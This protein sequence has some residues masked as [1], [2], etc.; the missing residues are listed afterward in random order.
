L[1]A[2]IVGVEKMGYAGMDVAFRDVCGE[3]EEVG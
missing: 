1:E 2:E 3:S